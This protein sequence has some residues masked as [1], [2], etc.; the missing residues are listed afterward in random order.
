MEQTSVEW[1]IDQAMVLVIQYMNGTLN[2]D[3]L[4]DD[5]F[6]IGTK[7]KEMEKEKQEYFFECGRNF[8]LTGEGT[9]QKV[10]DET[11]KSE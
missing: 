10:Y 1:L 4:E 5:I 7:A 3:T 9:F 8:Q 6:N 2:E 11:F